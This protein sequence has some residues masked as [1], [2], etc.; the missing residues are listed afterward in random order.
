MV[1]DS[2]SFRAGWSEKEDA[3]LFSLAKAAQQQG[4]PLRAVFEE[5]ATSFHRK[6][7]SVRNYYYAR[8]RSDG[9]AQLAHCP[10]FQPFT[11]AETKWLVNEVLQARARGE[12]VRACTLRLGEGET[13]RMLRYQNK[14]RAVLR[15][16][17]ALIARI[18]SENAAQALPTFDPYAVPASPRRAGRPKKT[19]LPPAER[20]SALLAELALVEGLN[21]P[22]LFDSLG[23]LARTAVQGAKA[24]RDAE[25]GT[26]LDREIEQLES[27]LRQRDELLQ[28]ERER[29]MLLL[30]AFRQLV[31]VNTEFLKRS[32]VVRTQDLGGY[33]KELER[34][35]RPCEQLMVEYR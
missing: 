30:D 9:G 10:A 6:P 35:V 23:T 26:R 34:S 32:A 28:N 20:A 22:A 21:V 7:N 27:R 19:A 13:R 31:R 4:R 8:V 2:T 24:L 1:Q 5:I 16:N 29:F 14:Y 33:L 18:N 3:A 15:A 25:G 11:E 12:S 17:P